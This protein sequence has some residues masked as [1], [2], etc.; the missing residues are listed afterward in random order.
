ME[1]GSPIPSIIHQ[2]P[3]QEIPPTFNRTNKFTRGFVHN[4]YIPLFVRGNVRRYGTRPHHDSIRRN[5]H[6]T[7]EKTCQTEN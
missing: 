7:G 5:H 2:V 4:H 6:N 1:F 3:T